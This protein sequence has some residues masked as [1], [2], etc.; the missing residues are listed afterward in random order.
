[1]LL[2][3]KQLSITWYELRRIEF[4]RKIFIET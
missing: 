1:M 3:W 4:E 2:A